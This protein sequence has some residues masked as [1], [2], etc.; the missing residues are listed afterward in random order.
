MHFHEQPSMCA[1]V[2]GI[3]SYICELAELVLGFSDPS[4]GCWW[5]RGA[6]LH[7]ILPAD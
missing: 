7:Q 1:L 3:H 5:C 2:S 4:L 6:K